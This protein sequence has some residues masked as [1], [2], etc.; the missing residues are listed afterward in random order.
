MWPF[1]PIV[2]RLKDKRTGIIPLPIYRLASG[3]FLAIFGREIEV[4]EEVK[5]LL[6]EVYLAIRIKNLNILLS[7]VALVKAYFE[8]L[9]KEFEEV[10][11][12]NRINL[13]WELCRSLP[14]WGGYLGKKKNTYL[15]TE[16]RRID[17]YKAVEI[18]YREIGH[19]E[20]SCR[21]EEKYLK[22]LQ[23]ASDLLL[24]IPKYKKI[25]FYIFKIC[26]MNVRYRKYTRV[27]DVYMDV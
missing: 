20:E 5:G 23:K 19:L 27:R 4:L 26:R 13:T 3:I 18:L 9:E 22:K 11:Y 2:E 16:V 7:Q 12:S 6:K 1:K 15:I 25:V 21:R 8:A 10:V 17:I 24:L 14:G